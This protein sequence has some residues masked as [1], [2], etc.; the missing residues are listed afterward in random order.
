MNFSHNFQ[1]GF[2]VLPVFPSYLNS[3]LSI[4]STANS[5]SDSIVMLLEIS[6]I[7]LFS[8]LRAGLGRFR[9]DSER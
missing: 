4:A 5:R 9:M 2:Q 8:G 3:I 1:L 6:Q 7:S